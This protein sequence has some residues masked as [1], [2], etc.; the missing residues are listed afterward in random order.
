VKHNN[1]LYVDTR[2]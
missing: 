2:Q 1:I